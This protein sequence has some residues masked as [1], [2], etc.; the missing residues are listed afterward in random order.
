V[1]KCI[2]AKSLFSKYRKTGFLKNNPQNDAVLLSKV[3]ILSRGGKPVSGLTHR[4]TFHRIS[5]GR[6]ARRLI[7]LVKD[8][9]KKTLASSAL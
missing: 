4:L 1:L 8:E 5:L 9:D 7:Y 2:N 3:G 6:P